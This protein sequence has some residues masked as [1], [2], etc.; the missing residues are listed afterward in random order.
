MLV[1]YWERIACLTCL[2]VQ[3]SLVVSLRNFAP[4]L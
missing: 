1:A 4:L 3:F 2:T